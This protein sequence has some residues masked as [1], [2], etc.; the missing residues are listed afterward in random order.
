MKF[1]AR[2]INNSDDFFI[3]SNDTNIQNLINEMDRETKLRNWDGYIPDTY[4]EPPKEVVNAN[5]S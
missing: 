4:I 5:N 2:N 3:T 1:I